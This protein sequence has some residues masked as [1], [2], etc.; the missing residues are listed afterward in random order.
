MGSNDKK[1]TMKHLNFLLAFMNSIKKLLRKIN[2]RMENKYSTSF[3][4]LVVTLIAALVTA[5]ILFLPNYLGVA[6]DGSTDDIMNAAGIYYI[7]DDS[8]ENYNN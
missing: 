3:L 4:A 2:A 1:R 6:G 8:D 7:G 5:N